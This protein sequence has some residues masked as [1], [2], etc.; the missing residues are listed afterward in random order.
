[1]WMLDFT[2]HQSLITNHL[3]LFTSHF[4]AVFDFDV[5]LQPSPEGGINNL[6]YLLLG[7]AWSLLLALASWLVSFV[8]GSI[9]GVMRTLP[10]R[11]LPTL[12]A[13]YV[14]LFRNVPLLVQLFVWFFVVPDFTPILGDWFK[15][16]L[17]PVWQ[18]FV[19]GTACLS[20]FTAARIAEQVR[21][22]IRALGP[23]QLG[24]GLAL[25]LRRS[26][27]YVLVLLPVAYR[28]LIPTLTSEF[29]NLIKNTA[30]AS[31]IGYVEL[32]QRSASMADM[33][34]RIYE[35]FTAGTL[36]YAAVNLLVMLLAR[37]LER[38]T[39]LPGF[40]GGGR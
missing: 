17:P 27:V 31:T 9:I 18:E 2:D 23:G 32:A 25:G 5:F 26:Q 7:L 30:V 10:G 29:L 16:Q 3:S 20:L 34:S 6:T 8:V 40:L 21:S 1:M 24:A 39:A 28:I 12:G 13:W 35:A 33:T 11:V 4:L 38:R 19:S 37:I 22:G 36:L 14:E 15:Q